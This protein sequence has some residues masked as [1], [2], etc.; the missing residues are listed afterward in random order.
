MIPNL[1]KENNRYRGPHESKKAN[2]IHIEAKF[3]LNIIK[4]K[5]I[6]LNEKILTVK[7]PKKSFK[8]ID[9]LNEIKNTLKHMEDSCNE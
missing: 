8:E 2:N 1:K 5:I 9:L 6:E 7:S 4:N 3:N